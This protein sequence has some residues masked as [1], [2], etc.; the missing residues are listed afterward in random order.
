MYHSTALWSTSSELSLNLK[1]SNF[2][3]SSLLPIHHHEG[4][5]DLCQDG[6]ILLVGEYKRTKYRVNIPKERITGIEIG[7]ESVFDLDI[8]AN[9][10]YFDR[11]TELEKYV[12]LTL[13]YLDEEDK[14]MTIY[15][16]VGY[17]PESKANKNAEFLQMATVL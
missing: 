15:L 6:S 16:C 17:D 12:P 8:D 1:P 13:H 3:K 4:T 5:I 11:R 9:D 10:I 7:S 2:G 14:D